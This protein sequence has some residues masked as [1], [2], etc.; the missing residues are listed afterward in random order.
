ML[1]IP[2]CV[3]DKVKEMVYLLPGQKPAQKEDLTME[4]SSEP[5]LMVSHGVIS[6]NRERKRDRLKKISQKARRWEF[7]VLLNRAAG[8]YLSVI[9]FFAYRNT[10][11]HFKFIAE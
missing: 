1:P 4:N 8:L 6:Y 5:S 7:K 11:Y 10:Q 3:P 2:I 9:W